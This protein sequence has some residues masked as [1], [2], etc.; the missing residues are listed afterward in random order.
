MNEDEIEDVNLSADGIISQ[1]GPIG[2]GATGFPPGNPNHI[3][4]EEGVLRRDE[5]TTFGKEEAARRAWGRATAHRAKSGG[6]SP[7]K[8]N[9]GPAK[10]AKPTSATGFRES[11]A[12]A[13]PSKPKEKPRD[14]QGLS[15]TV[16]LAH[17]MLAMKL[18]RAEFAI[19]EDEAYM[20]TKAA[21]DLL[22]HYGIKLSGKASAWSAMIYAVTIIYGTRIGAMIIENMKKSKE[23]AQ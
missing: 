17:A 7:R 16:M 14:I 15:K 4:T 8:G 13:I 21:S 6:A 18:E 23:Q 9:A 19:N 1:A 3:S 12:D 10:A 5:T 2:R 22:D 11:M 20:L